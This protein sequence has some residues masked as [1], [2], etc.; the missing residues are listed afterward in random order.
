M[1]GPVYRSAPEC[2][3]RDTLSAGAL[4]EAILLVSPRPVTLP[5]LLSATKLPEPDVRA[6]IGELRK[7]YSPQA[8]GVVLRE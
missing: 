3:E 7:R 1:N 4:I 6:A 8:S 5:V 2:P